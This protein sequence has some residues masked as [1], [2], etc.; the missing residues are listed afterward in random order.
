MLAQIAD[1]VVVV[2]LAVSVNLIPRAETVFHEEQRFLVAVIHHIHGDAQAERVDAPAP[3]AG[4]NMRVLQR[5]N[6]I[7]G[8]GVAG[9]HLRRRAA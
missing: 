9:V 1:A 4:L 6:D 7:G 5:F 8:A 2:N 3:F